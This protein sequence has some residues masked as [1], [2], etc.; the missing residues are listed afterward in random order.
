MQLATPGA[1]HLDGPL[2]L[3]QPASGCSRAL[4]N[5]ATLRPGWGAIVA[6]NAHPLVHRDAQTWRDGP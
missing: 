6:Q 1:H 4:P 2:D 3:R 5:N